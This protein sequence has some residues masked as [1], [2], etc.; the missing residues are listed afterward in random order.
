[1]VVGGRWLQGAGADLRAAAGLPHP[2]R[3]PGEA[4]EASLL[5]PFLQLPWG[6]C[7]EGRR[8]GRVAARRRPGQSRPPAAAGSGHVSV[9]DGGEK[10]RHG[11]YGGITE[12]VA[13]FRLMLETCY[14]QHGVDH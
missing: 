1:M 13:D 12:F 9:E 10:P 11:Q 2:G 6:R 7:H 5:A 8:G 4:T 14:R 3:V